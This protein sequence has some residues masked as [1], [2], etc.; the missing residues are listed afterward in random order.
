MPTF[1]L[2]FSR[3]G[4]QVVCQYYLMLRLGM[5]GYRRIHQD[6]YDIAQYFARRVEKIGPFERAV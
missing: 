5:D 3:P 4:G 6:C 1:A 2:N